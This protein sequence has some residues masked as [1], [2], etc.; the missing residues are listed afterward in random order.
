MRPTIQNHRQLTPA[1]YFYHQVAAFLMLTMRFTAGAAH[2]YDITDKLSVG[3]VLAGVYQIMDVEADDLGERGG[4]ALSLQPEFSFRP[5]ERD[6]LF[7]KL[8]FAI[9]NG[10]DEFF[11]SV[12]RP[13]AA[14]L[15]DQVKNINGSGR[16]YLLTA[17]YKHTFDLG[18]GGRLGLAAGLIDAT[19]YLDVNAFANDEYTQ[20]MSEALVNGPNGFFPSY[21][22]GGALEWD[23]GSVEFRAV[24]MAVNSNKDG[25]AYQFYGIQFDYKVE[26]PLGKGTYRLI[27]DGTSDDFLDP[28][29][30]GTESRS[31]AILSLDQELGDTIGVFVRIGT[32]EDDAAVN[33]KNLFSGGLNISGELWGRE[34]DNVGIGYA[35]LN[36]GNLDID[37]S[38][39]A[40]AYARLVLNDYL[41][42][43]LDIQYIQERAAG[44]GAE[45]FVYGIRLVLAEF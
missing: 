29:G 30:E 28:G 27:L 42:L 22:L 7:T 16:D 19:E 35:F 12:L 1:P 8:G 10:L 17:W 13:W 15:E 24:V 9:G 25:N 14:A 37:Y 3:G 38:Q 43:T 18:R 11:P 21:D 39:V 20:F 34:R 45:G 41:A 4:G 31:A 2:A 6:E 26:T 33:F 40:E 36:G 23:S 5:T 32:Q 44:G